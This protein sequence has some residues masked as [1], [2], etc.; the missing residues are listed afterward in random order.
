[1]PKFKYFSLPTKCYHIFVAIICPKIQDLLTVNMHH[2][3]YF[4]LIS[5][6]KQELSNKVM[7]S[8]F[9]SRSHCDL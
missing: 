7:E 5:L 6:Y 9:I 2:F 8:Y 1:M 3:L 4:V